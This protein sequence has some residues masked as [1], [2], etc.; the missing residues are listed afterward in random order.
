MF[1]VELGT[2]KRLFYDSHLMQLKVIPAPK[3]TGLLKVSSH[4]LALCV[5]DSRETIALN[6]L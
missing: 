6:P 3:A 2:A 4:L 1:I 5:S